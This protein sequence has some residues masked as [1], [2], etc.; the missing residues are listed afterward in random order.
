M[1]S[2]EGKFISLFPPGT[3][4]DMI[5]EKASATNLVWLVNLLGSNFF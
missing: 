4:L 5:L 1:P 2:N 3:L